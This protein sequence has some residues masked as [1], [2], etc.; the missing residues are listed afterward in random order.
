MSPRPAEHL[1]A[2][3][4][5]ILE[6][7]IDYNGHLSEAFYVLIFGH[8]TD[9]VMGI[10]GMGPEYRERAGASLYTVEAHI[11]YLQEVPRGSSVDVWTAIAGSAERKLHVAHEMRVVGPDDAAGSGELVATEEILALHVAGEP[12][13]ARPFPEEIAARIARHSGADQGPDWIGRA[14][15]PLG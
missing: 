13:R 10:L 4:T 6:E 14:I 7:W 9:Q 12:V 11:R 5:Q 2:Y 3:S 8:A 1:P 15:R